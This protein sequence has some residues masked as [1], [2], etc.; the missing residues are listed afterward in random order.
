MRRRT[1]SKMWNS[2]TYFKYTCLK[3]SYFSNFCAEL[4][5]CVLTKY[6]L[7]WHNCQVTRVGIVGIVATCTKTGSYIGGD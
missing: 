5:L 4:I 1:I 7:F 3:D 6:Y 2:Y